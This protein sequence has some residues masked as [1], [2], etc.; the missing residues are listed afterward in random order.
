MLKFIL[1]KF[2]YSKEK[3]GNVMFCE[4]CGTKLP[5]TADFC[6]NCGNSIVKSAKVAEQNIVDTEIQLRVKPTFSFGYMVLPSLIIYSVLIIIFSLMFCMMSVIAGIVIA[7]ICFIL[8]ALILGI[9]TAINKKQYDS[10]SYDFYK[11]KVI[12]KDSFLNLS[13]KEVKY[14]YIREVTMRQTFVQRYFNIGNIILFTNAETGFG[15]GIYIM[16]VEDVQ[17]VYKNIK[18]II[19]V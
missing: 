9:K 13:E 1:D 16:N 15:N 5:D 4:R 18:S 14:K 19:D 7:L 11:T 2:I 3:E 17:D 12:Y 8:L 10:Y 6:T